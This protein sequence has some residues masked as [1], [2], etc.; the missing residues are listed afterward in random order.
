MKKL[1]KMF[2]IALLLT[3]PLILPRAQAQSVGKLLVTTHLK[4]A[5]G[6]YEQRKLYREFLEAY[7]KKCPY[8]SHFDI[9]EMP[10]ANDN[11]QIEWRYEV[12]NW[13]GITHFYNWIN[14]Q[15]EEKDNGIKTALTP[16]APHYAL[17]G[18]IQVTKRTK[19]ELARE[20]SKKD[21]DPSKG[22]SQS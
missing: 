13:N 18:D 7:M 20:R 2:A 16:Y 5:S 12:N 3:A 10:G 8:I 19:S 9:M 14:E 4:E 17:G 15:I 11:H 21:A 1:G 6:T 22:N